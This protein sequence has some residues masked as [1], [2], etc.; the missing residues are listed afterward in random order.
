MLL[1]SAFC[2]GG[3]YLHE[4]QESAKYYTN[5]NGPTH[6]WITYQA[7]LKLKGSGEP[8]D[9]YLAEELA[10]YL[11]K[12]DDSGG[13]A[14]PYL[15]TTWT[16]SA[17]NDGNWNDLEN[18]EPFEEGTALL[19]GAWEE[20]VP[21]TRSRN[22]FWNPDG[23]Y[24]SGYFLGSSALETAQETDFPNAVSAY[25]AGNLVYAFW[26][27]GRTSHLLADMSV[28]AHT[29][30]DDH[31]LDGC[32]FEDR[33]A[34]EY[35]DVGWKSPRTEIPDIG[36]LPD[37][38]G[39]VP[40]S[41]DKSLTRLFYNMAE[42][43]NDFPSFDSDGD[44]DYEGE[45]P[46]DRITDDIDFK[47]MKNHKFQLTTRAIGYVA[48]L[49]RLFGEKTKITAKISTEPAGNA[50]TF[51][52]DGDEFSES[53]TF[54]WRRNFQRK[55]S[56]KRTQGEYAFLKW[57]DGATEPE[58]AVK[59]SADY[60][61]SAIFVIPENSIATDKDSIAVPE[62][63]TAEF[64]VK[65]TSQ[66]ASDVTVRVSVADADSDF[67]VSS[68]AE[69]IFTSTN[70]DAYQKVEVSAAED[71]D[72]AAGTATISCA[73]SG[74]FEKYVAATELDDDCTLTVSSGGNGTT[75][76][77]GAAVV[78][79]NTPVAV[80]ASAAKNY[81][82]ES[83]SVLS[84]DAALADAN[85][86]E[87]TA[88]ASVDSEISANFAADPPP[89][90]QLTIAVSPEGSG[91][92]TPAPGIYAVNQGEAQEISASPSD[93]FK[94]IGWTAAGKAKIS[95][96]SDPATVTLSGDATLTAN[97]ASTDGEL[98]TAFG[99]IY[100]LEVASVAGLANFAKKPKVC[101]SY[102][103]RS[104]GKPRN[105][106]LRIP[107][108]VPRPIKVAAC[109]WLGRI[110]L[111]NPK[112]WTATPALTTAAILAS[113]EDLQPLPC[114]LKV[115]G[116]DSLKKTVVNVDTGIDL[117]L[118]PPS[119]DKVYDLDGNEITDCTAGSKIV[120][121]GKFFGRALPL[122]W[123]EYPDANGIIRRLNLK[124]DKT[125]LP[126]L[127]ATK[128]PSCMDFNTGK[129]IITAVIPTKFPASWNHDTPHNIVLDNKVCRTTIAFGTK[130]RK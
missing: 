80:S 106:A 67:S 63:G 15:G 82:F 58:I 5:E 20:D 13:P 88:T 18:S 51:S 65:L 49:Y 22:H 75:K 114:R 7:Y 117:M 44:L 53:R 9:R 8:D 100:Y 90:A 128:K 81:H 3:Q 95:E 37:Y 103:D 79:K 50:L 46:P 34:K 123:L 74:L 16:D 4:T 107:A 85:S 59:P 66:P 89:S 94:F 125:S 2:L 121:E 104:T 45:S 11:K 48:A 28:P 61:V 83:W 98:S 32:L 33:M 120:I 84:G 87:T 96:T 91:T 129:S 1:T 116:T 43:S 69:L 55:L 36:K 76:P 29:L 126:F 92:T 86:A 71:D 108:A 122:V 127:D 35:K 42:T 99:K 112:T 109:E 73:A 31:S 30:I 115:G 57:S 40:G 102:I 101:A 111:V 23:D 68:G 39:K 78:E 110:P 26:W 21:G 56:V 27:L 70:W 54:A 62:G 72:A 105:A 24:D 60:N 130:L 17:S 12:V 19:E 97:F 14:S 6:G 38:P 52:V 47:D 77:S 25:K 10:V 118:M 41:Y 113:L 119:I 124:I 93:G 64:M